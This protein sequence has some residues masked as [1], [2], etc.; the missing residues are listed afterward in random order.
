MAAAISGG[1]G[2]EEDEMA[3]EGGEGGRG[4]GRQQHGTIS[5]R[6]RPCGRRE[7]GKRA[8]GRIFFSGWMDRDGPRSFWVMEEKGS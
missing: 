5:P 4:G 7:T 8:R 1:K 2:R 6:R 3:E